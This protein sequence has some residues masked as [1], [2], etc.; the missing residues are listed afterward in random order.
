MIQTVL[1]LIASALL[2]VGCSQTPTR[3]DSCPPLSPK[4]EWY[5]DSNG[6][7]YYPKRSQQN[8]LIYIEQLETCATL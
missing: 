3:T 1:P 5:S 6:G 2:L 7:A 8:L 4:L